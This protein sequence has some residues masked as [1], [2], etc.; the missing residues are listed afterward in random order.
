MEDGIGGGKER[1]DYKLGLMGFKGGYDSY[2]A[3]EVAFSAVKLC[4]T[5]LRRKHLEIT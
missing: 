3:R 4:D 1:G 2:R 5:N